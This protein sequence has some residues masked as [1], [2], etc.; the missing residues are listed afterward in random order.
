MSRLPTVSADS[1]AWGTILNDFLSQGIN[2]DG[3]LKAARVINLAAAPYSVSPTNTATANATAIMQAFTDAALIGGAVYL[4]GNALMYPCD[5]L[6][7]PR[8]P[9]TFFG[10][11]PTASVLLQPSGAVSAMLSGNAAGVPTSGAFARISGNSAQMYDVNLH[12]VRDIGFNAYPNFGGNTKGISIPTQTGTRSQYLFERVAVYAPGST[13]FEVVDSGSMWGSQIRGCVV[14]GAGGPGFDLG[15]DMLIDSCV[16]ANCGVEGFRSI[17]GG[18]S[19]QINNCKAFG[20]GWGT[21]ARGIGFYVKQPNAGVAINNCDAQD[22]RAEG[23]VIE[24]S[25]HSVTVNGFISDSC[26]SSSAGTYSGMRLTDCQMV[27][28]FGYMATDRNVGGVAHQLRALK[29]TNPNSTN[30]GNVVHLSQSPT[31]EGNGTP[32]LSDPV[33]STS[34]LRGTHVVVGSSDGGQ[35]DVTVSAGVV[36]ALDPYSSQTKQISVAANVTSIP[37]PSNKHRGC[38]L[39]LQ[40]NATGAF[41]VTGGWNAVFKGTALIPITGGASGKSML[42]EFEYDG[43]NWWLTNT[44]SWR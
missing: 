17:N 10:D 14:Y 16:A 44:P 6:T 36:G 41:N 15:S 9:I 3:L 29:V 32:T 25:G 7:L 26:S 28:V 4:P 35:S 11:G 30:A 27:K 34:D 1:G 38:R 24:T 37:A 20:C 5:P 23:L 13:A 8:A 42:C 12:I 43:T 31:N 2:T 21:E 19:I 18:T 22:C 33:D 39:R 40:F